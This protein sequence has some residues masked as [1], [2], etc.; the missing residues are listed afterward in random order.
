M[1]CLDF[2]LN[3]LPAYAHPSLAQALPQRNAGYTFRI[4]FPFP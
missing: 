2:A 4:T 3:D 1:Q